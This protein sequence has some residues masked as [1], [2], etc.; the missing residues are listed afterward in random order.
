MGTIF[1]APSTIK[2]P[3]YSKFTSNKDGKYKFD[4]EGFNKAEKKY[5]EELKEFCLKRKKGKYVGET[6]KFPFADG[7]AVYMV[8]SLRPL[9][10]VHVPLGDAWDY[11]YI[12]R[13]KASDIVENIE[14]RKSLEKL[15]S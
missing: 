2:Q 1:S 10:L 14:S 15:F 8:A 4:S 5:M 9:E 13:L 12:E 7:Q 3:N 11:P 6:V